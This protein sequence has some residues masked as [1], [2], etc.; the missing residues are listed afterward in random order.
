MGQEVLKIDG[1]V[2]GINGSL[3]AR[4]AAACYDHLGGQEK[5][6]SPSPRKHVGF[7]VREVVGRHMKKSELHAVMKEEVIHAHTFQLFT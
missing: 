2:F 3:T 5:K 1:L 6:K 4:T 7:R